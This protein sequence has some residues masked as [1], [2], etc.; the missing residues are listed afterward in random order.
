MDSALKWCG[1]LYSAVFEN[2]L[3]NSDESSAC[4]QNENTHIKTRITF[5]SF[6]T[7]RFF[8]LL[9]QSIRRNHHK[10]Q[11]LQK[12][13]YIQHAPV[14]VCAAYFMCIFFS[15]SSFKT[16]LIT[17]LDKCSSTIAPLAAKASKLIASSK[18]FT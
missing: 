14:C 16:V 9:F 18:H 7:C 5:R 10:T 17:A 6:R 12:N 4:T 8:T 11:H 2:S 13:N 15:S 1:H 3:L